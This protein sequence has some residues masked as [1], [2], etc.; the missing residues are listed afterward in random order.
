MPLWINNLYGVVT[1]KVA[2]FVVYLLFIA[3][4]IWH[5]LGLFQTLMR[6][7]VSPLLISVTVLLVFIYFYNLF[8]NYRPAAYFFVVWSI[9][10]ITV[11]VILEIIGTRTGWLFGRYSYGTIWQPQVLNVPVAIGF[12]WL[13]ILLSSSSLVQRYI[14]KAV[15]VWLAVPA[16]MVLFDVFM[17]PASVKLGYWSW[18]NNHI[19][20]FNYICWFGAGFLFVVTGRM[21]NLKIP[22]PA[23]VQHVYFAQLLYFVLVILK[24]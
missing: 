12:A 8:I 11:S 17:E 18:D 19:P 16:L 9:L 13:G 23:I 4:G 6:I 24:K 10:V 21:Q 1:G 22:L 3:G 7:M 14:P 5:L 20:L 15:P 2:V